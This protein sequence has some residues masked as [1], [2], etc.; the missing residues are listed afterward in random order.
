MQKKSKKVKKSVDFIYRICY[1]TYALTKKALKSL[2]KSAKKQKKLL[3]KLR[4]SDILIARDAKES[5]AR[6][7]L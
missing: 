1:I 7:D 3:T 6:N 5:N 2:E 4:E